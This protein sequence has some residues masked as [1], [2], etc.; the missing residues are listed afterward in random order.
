MCDPW[1]LDVLQYDKFPAGKGSKLVEHS[2]AYSKYIFNADAT[3]LSPEAFAKI[4]QAWL[5]F[6]LMIEV[7][8]ISGVMINVEDS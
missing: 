2:S 1:Y 6:G 7:L 5:F 4:M 8:K 3:K